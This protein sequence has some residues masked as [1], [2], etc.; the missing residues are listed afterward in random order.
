MTKR[1]LLI[2]N[3]VFSQNLFAIAQQGRVINTT[4]H[5]VFIAMQGQ[6]SIEFRDPDRYKI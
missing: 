2:I 6:S 5:R 3:V 1:F 4:T